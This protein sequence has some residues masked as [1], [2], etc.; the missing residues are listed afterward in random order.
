MRGGEQMCKNHGL[1]LWL[2]DDLKRIEKLII[3]VIY[4]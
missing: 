3:S 1:G 4:M 2:P